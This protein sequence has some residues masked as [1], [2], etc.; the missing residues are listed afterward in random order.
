[1]SSNTESLS[2]SGGGGSGQWS[3]HASVDSSWSSST[4]MSLTCQQAAF[5]STDQHFTLNQTQ[6]DSHEFRSLPNNVATDRYN[7]QAGHIEPFSLSLLLPSNQMLASPA[8]SVSWYGEQ[9]WNQQPASASVYSAVE[10]VA[11]IPAFVSN[12]S[13]D[14]TFYAVNEQTL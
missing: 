9:Q 10:H 12:A 14:G 8:D 4:S 5:T 11:P 7:V 3:V 13:Y 1:L 6:F 2:L